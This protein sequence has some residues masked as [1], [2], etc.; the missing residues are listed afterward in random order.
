MKYCFIINPNSGKLLYQKTIDQIKNWDADAM[1]FISQSINDSNFFI[2]Q[3]ID[4]YDIFVAVGGD[5]TI[6]SVAKNLLYTDKILA[7]IPMGSGN[8]FAIETGFNKDIDQLF[9]KIKLQKTKYID[10]IRINGELSINVSG[11]GFDAQIVKKFEQTSRG[12]ANYFLL[13]LKT[14]FSDIHVNIL[15]NEPYKSFNGKYMMMN[16]ANSKQFGN[17]AF[18]AP[19]AQLED[20]FFDLVLLKKMPFFYSLVFAYRMMTKKLK[21][22]HHYQTFRGKYIQLNIDSKDWHLDGEYKEIDNPISLKMEA[23]SLRILI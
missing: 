13:V 23:K 5:G 6:S 12:K 4:K 20:G 11:C 16:I 3:N 9:Q 22:D 7:A 17:N 19:Q 10:T 1:I 8:G 2:E 21:N 15:F 18:I 14:M